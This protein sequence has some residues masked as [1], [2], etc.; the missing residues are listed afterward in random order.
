MLQLSKSQYEI[1]P[2]IRFVDSP[3]I[4]AQTSGCDSLDP[5]QI[6]P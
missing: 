5:L 2:Q 1:R 6:Y 4:P 3:P